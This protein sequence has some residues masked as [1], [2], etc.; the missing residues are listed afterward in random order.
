MFA[1]ASVDE[2]ELKLLNVWFGVD[3]GCDP[4]Q[5]FHALLFHFAFFECKHV[6]WSVQAEELA[7]SLLKDVDDGW[8]VFS[9]AL[10][11]LKGE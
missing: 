7:S 9:F 3:W 10:A 6:P 5:R 8:N 2:A 1:R 11:L 4:L